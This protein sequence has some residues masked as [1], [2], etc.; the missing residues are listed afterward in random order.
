MISKKATKSFIESLRELRISREHSLG[1]FSKMIGMDSYQYSK[2]ERGVIKLPEDSEIRRW[3]DTLGLNQNTPFYRSMLTQAKFDR[4]NFKPIV[5]DEE[6]ISSHIPF[7]P[8]LLNDPDARLKL[9]K[10]IIEAWTP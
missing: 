4:D 6:F 5:V 9:R 1:D 8:W 2:L 7:A 10:V 3:L